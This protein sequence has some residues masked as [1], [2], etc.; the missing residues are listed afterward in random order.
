MKILGKTD[1]T[2]ADMDIIPGVPVGRLSKPRE[3]VAV[4]DLPTT[5]ALEL[6]AH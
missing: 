6:I 2:G 1:W 3:K 4:T 5:G